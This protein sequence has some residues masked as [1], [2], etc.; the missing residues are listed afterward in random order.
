MQL[1]VIQIELIV[2]FVK[3]KN[4]YTQISIAVWIIVVIKI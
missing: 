3:D 4:Q 2:N 1:N